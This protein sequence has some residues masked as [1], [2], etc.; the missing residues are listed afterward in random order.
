MASL[1]QT[2]SDIGPVVRDGLMRSLGS[3]AIK[4]AAAGLTYLMFVVLSR[5]M[6]EAAYGRFAFGFSLATMLA[7]GASMGQQTAI[8]RYWPEQMG[9]GATGKAHE[10]LRAGWTLTLLAGF[11][12]G[13]ALLVGAAVYGWMG[14]GFSQNMH[15]Y[16]A[17]L[18][19]LPLGAAE[20]GSAALRAQGSVWTALAPRDI[21]WRGTV[22][23][24]AVGLIIT[25]AKL[26]GAAGLMLTAGVLVGALLLQ[27]L[28]ARL[29]GYRQDVGFHGLG[30]YWHEH[31]RASRWFFLGT[32]ADSA[33]LNIDIVLV[34]L[35]VAAESAGLYFNAFRTAG[36]LTLFMFSITLVIAPMVAK[37]YHAGEMRK[38][39]AVTTLCAWAGFLFSLAV[40]AIYWFFGDLVLSLFGET[41]ADGQLVLVLLSLGLLADAATG[42]T[43]IVMMMTGHERDY[44]RLFGSIMVVGFLLQLI[45]I[46]LYGVL[47]AALVNAAA[48][49][50]AQITIAIWTRRHV[51]LDTS[52]LGLWAMRGL[53]SRA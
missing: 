41:Y 20:Y 53:P 9:R 14:Q 10:A 33:A 11:A 52:L 24:V 12:L 29:G 30:S 4:I 49:A 38:A 15:L 6:T 16:A 35:F 47:A 31:G 8:L 1:T 13:L 27:V 34:G 43:R 36:L 44:V 23:L 40:F 7:I 21:L 51:G 42:P 28:L 2:T 45:A 17:A 22:V 46:P 19:V 32:V 26:S 25:G 3:L 48:R 50:V 37:H 18:L 39:Q 5:A